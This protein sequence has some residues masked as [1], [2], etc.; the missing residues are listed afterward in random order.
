MKPES[1]SVR[2]KEEKTVSLLP[3]IEHRIVHYTNAMTAPLV[4]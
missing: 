1:R 3:G 2:F 4:L